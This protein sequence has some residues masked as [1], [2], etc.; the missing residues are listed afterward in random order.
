MLEVT[1]EEIAQVVRQ[2]LAA[3][4]AESKD[5]L[6]ETVLKTIASILTSFGI[7]EDERQE[8]KLDFQH[9][10]RSRKAYDLIQTTGVKAAIGLIIGSILTTLWLGVQAL[11]HR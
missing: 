6:D 3:E 1:Q 11:L 8:V 5:H 7:D 9:L 10:R 2:V 4:R